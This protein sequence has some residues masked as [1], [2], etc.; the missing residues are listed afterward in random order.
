MITLA[1]SNQKGGVG[2]TT[3]CINL[4][5]E[6]GRKGY[7]VLSVDIDPQA[8]CTSGLG[9]ALPPKAP[10][11]YN[12]LLGDVPPQ[13]AILQTKWKG[14]SMLPA[15]LDLAGAEI[16]LASSISRE[17][18]MRRVLSRI[19]GFD[20]AILDCPPSLGMLTVNALVAADKL[21]IPI[22]CEYFALEGLGQLSR[23]ISLVK[24]GLN[25]NLGIDGILLT[26]HD[27]RTRLSID[28]ADEVRRQFGDVVFKT[29]IPRNVKLAE[30]PSY[31]EPICY[32]DPSCSGAKAYE[33]FAEEV[34][35]LWLKEE[36]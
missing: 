6:L 32:Y 7:S 10:S 27:S 5:A 30:A 11:L 3:T 28:V 34:S 22:Q 13:E 29:F 9:V 26:M 18:K 17:T 20:I 14:V 4:A 15:T 19:E 2:K 33:E 25:Q 36:D 35:T 24:D 16:E 8:N 23:T 1:V 12:V 21:V 31:A